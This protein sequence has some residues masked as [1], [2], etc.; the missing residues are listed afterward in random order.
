M[1]PPYGCFRLSLTEQLPTVSEISLGL[2]HVVQQIVIIFALRRY[3]VDDAVPMQ[4]EYISK[5]AVVYIYDLLLTISSAN[6]FS[7]SFPH[8][9]SM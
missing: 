1:R 6:H 4:S 3:S 8:I 7:A 9:M 5:K 2:H